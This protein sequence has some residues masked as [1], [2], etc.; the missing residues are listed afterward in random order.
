M[1]EAV[2]ERRHS[3]NWWVCKFADWVTIIE[4]KHSFY[5]IKSSMLLDF[6]HI[7]VQMLN[8]FCIIENE[9]F[10]WFKA[11]SNNISDVVLGHLFYLFKFQLRSI[12]KLF[13]VCNLNDQWYIKSILKIF[14]H[15]KGNSMP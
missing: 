12:H 5:L 9:N 3:L 6:N 14:A 4:A 7:V 8:I 11:E 1:W 10:L 2:A 15:N 13:V